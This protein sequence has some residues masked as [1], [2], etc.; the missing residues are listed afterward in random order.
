MPPLISICLP[1]LNTRPFLEERMETI[2]AQTITDWELII[3]DSYS[4]D[5]SWEFFQKFKRDPR[6]RMYQ[7]P[8]EGIYAGWNECL[9]R[10]IGEYIYIATSDDTMTPNCLEELLKPLEQ[11]SELK[12]AACDYQPID[13]Q[14]RPIDPTSLQPYLRAF[15]GDCLNTPSIRNGRTEF[16]IQACMGPSW[17]TMTSV[18]F[19]RTLL[20]HTGLF[21]C[22]RGSSGDYEWSLRAMLASDLAF[23]PGRLATWRCSPQQATNQLTTRSLSHANFNCLRS[24]LLE[25]TQQLP[26]Q[27]SHIKGW[28]DEILTTWSL[29]CMGNYNLYRNIL[30]TQPSKFMRDFPLAVREQPRR[31]FRHVLHGFK[32]LP[33]YSPDRAAIA[34]HLI[35]L[36]HAPWPPTPVNAKWQPIPNAK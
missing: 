7:V 18:L 10:A 1:N 20:K 8:R 4:N 32:W 12:I 33:E 9:R 26:E 22:N 23:V 17:V 27:W 28:R 15:Y 11:L 21:P 16:L 29:E 6:I 30:L 2:L 25:S 3:C 31:L 13:E 19:R 5:G 24:V 34:Q 35:Q 14:G 36:F